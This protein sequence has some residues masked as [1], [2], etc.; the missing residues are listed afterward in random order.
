MFLFINFFLLTVCVQSSSLGGFSG[1]LEVSDLFDMSKPHR[2]VE[3]F[4]LAPFQKSYPLP[5]DQLQYHG[6][7]TLAMIYKNEIICAVDSRATVGDYV[8]SST[9]KKIFPL[10]K[11][12]IATMA[13]GAAD[14]A[15]WIRRIS[16]EIKILEYEYGSELPVKAVAKFFSNVLRD[17]RKLDVSVGSMVA[18]VDSTGPSLY[19]IDSEGS[20]VSGKY[21]CVG[22]GAS[23]AYAILDA[24]EDISNLPIDKALQTVALA[25]RHATHRDGYSG[26]YINV[27]RINETGCHHTLDDDLSSS[28]K[29]LAVHFLNFIDA[30]S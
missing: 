16:R 4:N 19:Y 3:P 9:V 29:G 17:L 10:T 1:N 6:T 13:G 28:F 25:V 23:L 21:F 26:G 30:Y 27:F 22:S 15:Y 20:C 12:M 8:G 11:S 7:T 14:C 24:A 2:L 5:A 18:G